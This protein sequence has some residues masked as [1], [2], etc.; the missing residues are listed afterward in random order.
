MSSCSPCHI[1]ELILCS[2]RYIHF[3]ALAWVNFPFMSCPEWPMEVCLQK[4]HNIYLFSLLTEDHLSSL[5]SANIQH[6]GS[7]TVGA[8]VIAV[9]CTIEMATVVLVMMVNYLGLKAVESSYTATESCPSY[10]PRFVLKTFRIKM[11]T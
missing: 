4:Q 8:L 9:S 3:V 7:R 6:V 2:L 5:L 1:R 11:E 10:M